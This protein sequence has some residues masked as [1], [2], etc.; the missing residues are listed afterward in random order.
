MAKNK[1]RKYGDNLCK[2]AQK[3]PERGTDTQRKTKMK[4]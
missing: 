2:K 3:V 1:K 4:R